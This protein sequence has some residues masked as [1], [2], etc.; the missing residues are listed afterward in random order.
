MHEPKTLEVVM[1]K[2]MIAE[3]NLAL[4]SGGATGGQSVSAPVTRSVVRGS[5]QRSFSLSRSH[6]SYFCNSQRFKKKYS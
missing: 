6:P 3:E 1:E 4:A 2:A 5:Q